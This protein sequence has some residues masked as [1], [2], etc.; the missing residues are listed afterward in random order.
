MSPD[1]FEPPTP[2]LM[3]DCLS[4][5][6]ATETRSLARHLDE[7]SPY[8]SPKAYAVWS[9]IKSMAAVSRDHA[10]RLSGLLKALDLPQRPRTFDPSV[11]NYHY[12]SLESLLPLLIDEKR[13]QIATYERALTQASDAD[14]AAVLAQLLAENRTHV[15]D[16]ENALARLA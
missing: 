2:D 15:S 11:A 12:Q 6:I 3:A 4:D 8:L 9:T 10:R 7:A 13:Q 14:L 5:L 1:T 16:L